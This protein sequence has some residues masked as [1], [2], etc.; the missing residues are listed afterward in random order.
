MRLAI[1]IIAIVG[2]VALHLAALF[3]LLHPNVSREYRAH[4]MERTST[5]WHVQH[6]PSTPEEGIDLAR[7]GW[8]DFVEYSYGISKVVGEGRWTDTQLGLRSGFQLKRSFSGPACVVLNATP[9]DSARVQDVTLA[10][11]DQTKKISFAQSREFQPYEVDF[12]LTRPASRL[13]LRFPKPLPRVDRNNPRQFGVELNK[14]QIFSQSCSEL[15]ELV[16]PSH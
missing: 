15:S 16:G 6:Y 14:V 13:E 8:P 7:P 12:N 10:F 11:G 5:D 1:G 4:Y 2:L 9:L 3:A